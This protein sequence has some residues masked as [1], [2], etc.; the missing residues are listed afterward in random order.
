VRSLT[1]RQDPPR[2]AKIAENFAST[3]GWAI[4][5]AMLA[6][7]FAPLL[8]A[9]L[10]VSSYLVMGAALP[11]SHLID[12]VAS[13]VPIVSDVAVR[14]QLAFGLLVAV[15]AWAITRTIALGQR[16]GVAIAGA[17][18][19]I[20]LMRSS[21]WLNAGLGSALA[22]GAVLVAMSATRRLAGSAMATAGNA[23]APMPGRGALQDGVAAA[24]AAT[25]ASIFEPGYA[26]LALPVL[27]LWRDRV[28]RRRHLLPARARH[29]RWQVAELWVTPGLL[30]AAVVIA[31][32][33]WTAATALLAPG[34]PENLTLA[35]PRSTLHAGR[36]LAELL[37]PTA[38]VAALAGAMGLLSAPARSAEGQTAGPW[39]GAVLVAI[40]IGGLLFDGARGDIGV[41]SVTAAALAAGFAIQGLAT[42]ASEQMMVSTIATAAPLTLAVGPALIAATAGFLV[43][44]PSLL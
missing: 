12:A 34:A 19:A 35:I 43:L 21:S 36:A 27:A 9:V 33:Q 4:M 31:V 44:A 16:S 25:L 42:M 15:A 8:A 24:L 37:G 28:W 41:A 32:V 38:V 6:I 26:G 40:A 11:P 18:A 3:S 1:I 39:L 29:R 23:A 14:G 13:W 10:V 17:V 22:T 2:S 20:L 5:A 30:V 7:R